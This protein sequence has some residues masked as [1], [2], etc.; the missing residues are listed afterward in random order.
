MILKWFHATFSLWKFLVLLTRKH[1]S[2]IERVALGMNRQR[3]TEQKQ[4]IE[5]TC[6]YLFIKLF[7]HKIH[8]NSKTIYIFCCFHIH[9]FTYFIDD[10]F[11]VQEEAN[12]AKKLDHVFSCN[13][14]DTNRAPSV[15]HTVRSSHSDNF[16]FCWRTWRFFMAATCNVARAVSF[17]VSQMAETRESSVEK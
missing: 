15:S 16:W 14:G 12:F 8:Y 5:A 1:W 10:L 3:V 11:I 6:V 9:R 13:L 7:H 4:T 17:S 2:V